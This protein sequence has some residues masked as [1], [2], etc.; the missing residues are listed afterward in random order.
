MA[1]GCPG[2]T[3]R[4]AASRSRPMAE[5]DM[6]GRVVVVTGGG[7]GLGLG[8]ARRFALA[9]AHAVLAELDVAAGMQAAEGL[10]REG[11]AAACAPLDVRDPTQSQALVERLVTSH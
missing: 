7:R 11:L 2:A 4:R 6:D 3:W 5:A 9:G 8:I 1:A 10:R